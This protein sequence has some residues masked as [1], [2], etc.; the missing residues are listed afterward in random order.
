MAGFSVVLSTLWGYLSELGGSQGFLGWVVASYSLGQL[1]ASPIFGVWSNY[2][3]TK[4]PLVVSTIINIV[5]NVAYCFCDA[6]PAYKTWA[7]L[8]TRFFVGFGAGVCVLSWVH[9]NVCLFVA[10]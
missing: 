4:E 8:I 9:L 7:L 5:G 2:R 1:L 10:C 6:L 3:G